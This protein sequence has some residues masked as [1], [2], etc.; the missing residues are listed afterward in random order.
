MQPREEPDF[1][2]I[3]KNKNCAFPLMSSLNTFLY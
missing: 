2:G 3:R 1:W